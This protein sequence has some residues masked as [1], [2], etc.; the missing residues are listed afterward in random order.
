MGD[1]GFDIAP[2][3]KAAR[4]F[5]SDYFCFLNSFS[6]LLDPGLV[7]EVVLPRL[8]GGRR[9][10]RRNRVLGK[11]VFEFSGTCRRKNAVPGV[12][13][14]WLRA[15]LDMRLLKYYEKRFDP[16]PNF[17]IRTN[18]FMM[19]RELMLEIE[20]HRLILKTHAHEFESGRNSLTRQILERG[21]KPIVVGRDGTGYEMDRWHISGTFRQ[22]EQANLLVADNQTMHYHRLAPE[23]REKLRFQTWGSVSGTA[24]RIGKS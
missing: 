22:G 2:Y 20:R 10:C 23:E 11:R 21:L 15:P 3:F 18:A 8:Q 17:H 7:V 14:K 4:D 12:K 13:W 9:S 19:K 1:S 24:T 6:V 16:F 5:Q